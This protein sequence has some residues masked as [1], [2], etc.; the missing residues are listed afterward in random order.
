MAKL[1]IDYLPNESV[2]HSLSEVPSADGGVIARYIDGT[3]LR[4]HM[5][6]FFTRFDYEERIAQNIANSGFHE[7]FVD[8]LM[9]NNSKGI[10]PDL[11]AGRQVESVEV[12]TTPSLFM[13]ADDS[14]T[15]EYTFTMK[16]TY[17][18]RRIK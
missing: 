18:D 13:V 6:T 5:F 12:V 16:V 1:N 10:F 17:K 8:W 15:A 11:G 4:E 3:I 9:E 7:R 2:H 14:Q